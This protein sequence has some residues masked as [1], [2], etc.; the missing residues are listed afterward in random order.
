MP[1]YCTVPGCNKRSANGRGRYCDMHYARLRRTGNLD[2]KEPKHLYSDIRGYVIELNPT[3]PL[4]RSKGRIYQHQRIFF[5]AFGDGPFDCHWCGDEVSWQTMHI[6]HLDED[7]TNNNLTNLV[8]ACGQC[9][10]GRS[11]RAPSHNQWRERVGERAKR[12]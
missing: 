2:K 11:P 10:M 3:H 5:D 12:L 6:D 9:N 7:K 1:K 8:A 4:A